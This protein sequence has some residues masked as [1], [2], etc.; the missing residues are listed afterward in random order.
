M[1]RSQC[2]HGLKNPVPSKNPLPLLPLSTSSG[3]P[4]IATLCYSLWGKYEKEGGHCRPS[5]IKRRGIFA[6]GSS[7]SFVSP[8]IASGLNGGS[9]NCG[10]DSQSHVAVFTIA[11]ATIERETGRTTFR[12]FDADVHNT[13]GRMISEILYEGGDR[14]HMHTHTHMHARSC[15][16]PRGGNF[17]RDI[18]PRWSSSPPFGP[19]RPNE[20]DGPI[21]PPI[22]TG[23]NIYEGARDHLVIDATWR[24]ITQNLANCRR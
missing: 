23:K 14:M 17:I 1:F 12:S 21:C 6:D 15:V 19:K 5:R 20:D 13:D 3:V 11:F 9:P 2:K 22:A 16:P 10:G 24:I 8:K 18:E 4:S 7:L